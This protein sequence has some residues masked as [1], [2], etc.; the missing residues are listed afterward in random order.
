MKD[1]LKNFLFSTRLM[2]I[3]FIVFAVA[4]AFGTFI[5]SKYSTETARIWVYNA[6]WFE[7][8]MVFFVINFIGNMRR[9]RLLRWEKWPVLTLHLSWILIIVGAF[10]TRYISFE[11]MM[12]IR[13]GNSE[14][15]FYSDKTYLTAYVDGEIDGQPRRKTL[16][17]DLIVT[18]EAIK[19]N[20]PWEDDYNGQPF[21]I[22]Y[23]GFIDGA[24]EGLVPDENGK[25]YLKIVE[26]G[27]GQ[28][29]EH[30]LENGQVASIH[31]VLFALNKPTDGAINISTAGDAY[32]IK[33]PFEGDF[34]RMADQ[35]RG[36]VAKDSLQELQL[37][38][39]Y[40]MAGM[41]FV[42]PD[43]IV[44]GSYDI[45]KVPEEEVTEATLDALV[46]EVSAKGETVK[47][48]LLGGKGTSDFTEAFE[49]GGLDFSLS[50]GSKIH[51]LPFSIKLNDFI[52]EKY[53]GT[54]QGYA[55]FMS[56]V[57]VEDDRPYDYDIYMNHILDEGGYRF[58]QSSFHPDEKGTI[59][60]VN[61]DRWGTWITYLGY[62]LLYFGL[63]GIMFFGK[64]RFK[65]LGKSLEKLKSKKAAL[66]TVLIIGG[67]FW[68]QAQQ[69]QETQK[70]TAGDDPEPV[71]VEEAANL[72]EHVI[73]DSQGHSADDG[74]DHSATMPSQAQIDSLLKTT[75]VPKEHAEKFGKLVIQD[76]GGR[77]KP[78]N[79]FS[80]ELLRKLSLKDKFK[81]MNAD[82]VFLSMMLVPP[83]WYNAE[84]IAIDKK[85]QNDSL[86]HIIGVPEDQEFAKATDFF[87]ADGS[88]KLEPYLRDATATTNPN[89]IEKDIK[90]V[91]ARIGLL[92]QAL[93][94]RIIKIFPL[95]NHENNKWI[96]ALEYRSGQYQVSDSLYGNFIKNSIPYYLMTLREAKNTGDYSDANKL[97]EA[98]KQNQKNHGSEVLPS[99]QK[100]N[101]E[102]VYNKLDIFNHL[103]RLYAVLGLLM[104]FVL[105]FQIFKDRSIW[106]IASYFLKGTIVILFL[107]HTAGLV[108]RWYI[109]G[110]A[111]WSDAYESILY[112]SWAT[113]GMG[114][115]FAR[116]SDMTIAAS[117]FVTSML[118]FI[119][120][121]NW[122]DP[123]ISNLVPVL[124]SYWL[125]VHVAVIVGSY[126]PLTVGMILGVVC[127]ILM[128]LTNKGN[129][130][131]MSINIRELTIINELALT[132][133]L[134]ML[135]IGNFLGGQWANESWGRYW[136]WDPKETWAL[137]S[138]MVYAFVI[139]TRLVPGLRG[140][141][142]FN[143]LSVIA[144]GSIMM[145]YFGVNYY[146][147]G[148]HSYGQSGSAAIT[149]D[150][151]WFI[152]LGAVILGG[153]SFWR[154]RVHYGKG[155]RLSQG[156]SQADAQQIESGGK[157]SPASE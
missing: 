59:L 123:A 26:A 121:Q 13:E 144:F 115:L 120:H 135:T 78:I 109:S 113:M 76:D 29:H 41:Q 87:N 147:V 15:V 8:I 156:K 74:H 129:R 72:Q 22:S 89:Q 23:V 128:I 57:T 142:S 104:F 19:S 93:S 2:A 44:K 85:G 133:G 122:V 62:F 70:A 148:L 60:S 108:L 67:L 18:A 149:P 119:A 7:G 47:K 110:H 25:K 9:Y 40:N 28:R 34:M 155:N 145:T 45:I 37:R 49:V 61:H 43:P 42:I 31:G 69:A 101:T 17:E 99:D 136:G 106:R 124:D 84:F 80:S 117:A 66:T 125:M 107:W 65:D 38:S 51:E 82:Q 16:Q 86:R 111:P 50:Y 146:L 30:F 24:K 140:T 151:I 141:W 97:L 79:T 63:M 81:D 100:I 150:Y 118:L 131:R 138:I 36:E 4:M 6:W 91:H 46:V 54:E 35:F 14:N 98:F 77:M 105:I 3:L 102:V 153:I 95:L 132:V 157:V 12:P 27:D 48:K 5:E 64:T 90:N 73:D 68:G 56:K 134:V 21:S 116:R 11:G 126:G 139:H 32:Q 10:V 137:I 39:L 83:A 52:A 96:S 33:S 114:L 127:L 103:Y 53:P 1:L 55:S 154:Y 58:F 112:V 71:S 94:G 88:Y 20:L 152:A 143:F 130:A 92:D 75:I